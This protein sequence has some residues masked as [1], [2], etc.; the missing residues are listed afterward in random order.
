MSD[1][2]DIVRWN[3]PGAEKIREILESKP[4]GFSVSVEQDAQALVISYRAP[5]AGCIVAL[6]FA[7]VFVIAALTLAMF[8]AWFGSSSS[9]SLF[10]LRAFALAVAAALLV[11][12][13]GML[14]ESRLCLVLESDLA[15]LE[16]RDLFPKVM[17]WVPRSAIKE[18]AIVPRWPSTP[19]EAGAL[20]ELI[21]RADPNRKYKVTGGPPQNL[22]WFGRVLAAWSGAAFVSKGCK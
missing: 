15:T 12:L 7:G 11:G 8:V 19:V 18:V 21:L 6:L 5:R 1:A 17:W 13:V 9:A 3:G 20:F 10:M 4:K 2:S 22:L 14:R 16:R